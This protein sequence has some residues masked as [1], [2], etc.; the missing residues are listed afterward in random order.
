[1][2]GDQDQAGPGGM[3]SE[4]EGIAAL[5]IEGGKEDIG[6]GA[7]KP[8]SIDQRQEDNSTW[9]WKRWPLAFSSLPTRQA[10]TQ[11][12]PAANGG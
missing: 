2:C 1:M 6:T 8:A 12:Q 7:K 3:D 10:F 4:D 11:S 5:V 9:W